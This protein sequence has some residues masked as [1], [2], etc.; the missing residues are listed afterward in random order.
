ME[1]YLSVKAHFPPPP[2]FGYSFYTLT[3]ISNFALASFS[4]THTWQEAE[5][6][7]AAAFGLSYKV[8]S[9]KK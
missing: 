9:K 7:T 3:K 1:V 2:E 8:P 6:R 5:T 4:G